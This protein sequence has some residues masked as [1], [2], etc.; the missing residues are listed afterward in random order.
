M[1]HRNDFDSEKNSGGNPPQTGLSVW[2]A[3]LEKLKRIVSPVDFD[4]W[5]SD[6]RLAAEVDGEM[7]IAARDRMTYDRIVNEH[8]F[9]LMR[10]WQQCDPQNRPVR[11][12]C[13]RT[14][15]AE[16]KALAGDPWAPI[17]T[18]ASAE[19]APA[20]DAASVADDAAA[21][22]ANG[23][24]PMT[25]QSLVTGPSNQIASELGRR[26]ALGQPVGTPVVL[27]YG[28]Q[29]T[30]KT[31]LAQAIKALSERTQP[32]RRV[33]YLTAEEFLSAYQEGVRNRD[34]V[35]LKRRLRTANLLLIDD[36]HRIGGMP[37][38]EAELLQNLREV[39]AQGGTAVLVGD[40]VPGDPAGFG[41]RLRNEIRGAVSAE[42]GLPDSVMR[43]EIVRRLAAHIEGSHP[44]FHLGPQ[45]IEMIVLAVQG[46]G[47]E[48][49]GAVWNLFMESGFGANT[50]T[51]D[52]LANVL[53]RIKGDQRKPS[54]DII[55]RATNRVFNLQKGQLESESK[56]Q[57]LVYPRQLAMHIC[58]KMTQ[59]SLTQ[60]GDAFG[61]RDH[62]TVIYAVE[63]VLKRLATDPSVANDLRRI[64]DAVQDIMAN[65]NRETGT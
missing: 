4:R 32:Q 29:G 19:T 23:G 5:F 14:V 52:M 17:E 40:V 58:R 30:G 61:N 22:V 42:I 43:E 26:I 33:V 3:T 10:A 16:I 50:P 41:P 54:I 64:M 60:I 49:C 47:R 57:A 21:P 27:L 56:S 2:Q 31:H 9:V 46:P 36:L 25:F 20:P 37:S 38:T 63:R 28:P 65:G 34:T 18:P 55:K 59:R 13:W 7:L 8:R 39:T 44:H 51:P 62:S 12:I 15:S 11:L 24:P 53:K 48:L 1:D 35:D 6:L 45:L